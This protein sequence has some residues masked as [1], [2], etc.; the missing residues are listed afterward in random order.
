[1]NLKIKKNKKMR[2]LIKKLK[3]A[4]KHLL[5]FGYCSL[6]VMPFFAPIIIMDNGKNKQN[7][8]IQCEMINSENNNVEMICKDDLKIIKKVNNLNYEEWEQFKEKFNCKYTGHNG[9]FKCDNNIQIKR[10]RISS[11]EWSTYRDENHCRLVKID[12]TVS[13]NQNE[14]SC[15]NNINISNN[16]YK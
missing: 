8:T 5:F 16:F 9:E 3:A 7:E 1:M 10:N 14:W 11:I 12:E 4:K 13:E 2:K 6:L 15:D